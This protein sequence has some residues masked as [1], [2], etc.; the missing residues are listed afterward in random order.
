MSSPAWLSDGFVPTGPERSAGCADLRIRRGAATGRRSSAAPSWLVAP[1]R[2][3]SPDLLRA[4]GLVPLVGEVAGG[5]RQDL[6]VEWEH[7]AGRHVRYGEPGRGLAGFRGERS[8]GVG[9]EG[10]GQPV[11]PFGALPVAEHRHGVGQ[12]RARVR[13]GLFRHFAAGAVQRGLSRLQTSAGAQPAEPAVPDEECLPEV[14]GEDPA[15]D[16]HVAVGSWTAARGTCQQAAGAVRVT[17]RGRGRGR[18]VRDRPRQPDVASH[19]HSP[20][21][22]GTAAARAGK[23]G[24]TSPAPV[25]RSRSSRSSSTVRTGA[26]PAAVSSA[27]IS[28]AVP[29]LSSPLT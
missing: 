17:V 20:P 11:D 2:R 14:V 22:P 12:Q 21:P 26:V 15:G 6:V 23:S 27:S 28:P 18:Q 7:L 1:T 4:G 13:A 3:T 5:C 19:G 10:V 29:D 24:G 8:P 16:D 25:Y 9:R